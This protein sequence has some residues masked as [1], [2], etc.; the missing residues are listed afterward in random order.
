MNSPDASMSKQLT[1]SYVVKEDLRKLQE[2]EESY[3]P[4][5]A[6]AIENDEK[7][8]LIETT[9]TTLTSALKTSLPNEIEPA[10]PRKLNRKTATATEKINI[11]TN[12]PQPFQIEEID[13][14]V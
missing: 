11:V 1:S 8:Q 12:K 5:T 7:P 13:A 6:K 14:Q 10:Y 4:T 3:Q 9:K 2:T